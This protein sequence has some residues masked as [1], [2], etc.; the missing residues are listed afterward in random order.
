MALLL[1]AS[2]LFN[3]V[4]SGLLP[5]EFYAALGINPPERAEPAKRETQPKCPSSGDIEWQVVLQVAEHF[6]LSP[7]DP[8]VSRYVNQGSISAI[9]RAVGTLCR[10][11]REL[12][13]QI[14]SDFAE[15]FADIGAAGTEFRREIYCTVKPEFT[16]NELYAWNKAFDYYDWQTITGGQSCGE[17]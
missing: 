4:Q 17:T 16:D 3:L 7:N 14:A 8:R 6:E 15:H 11:Y 9:W 1:L 13:Y 12:G 5:V 10:K 2:L